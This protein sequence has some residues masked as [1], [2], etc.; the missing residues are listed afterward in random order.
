MLL[1]PVKR[2]PA[3]VAGGLLD[4][5]A[6][7]LLA[8]PEK[9]G[10][11]L[12]AGQ[13]ALSLAAGVDWLGFHIPEPRRVLYVQLEVAEWRLEERFQRQAAVIGVNQGGGM[14]D[15]LYAYT[16][17]EF[18]T[19]TANDRDHLHELIDTTK[20]DILLLD[21][22]YLIHSGDSNDESQ[23]SSVVRALNGLLK[24]VQGLVVVAHHAKDTQDLRMRRPAQ[25]ISGSSVLS[26]WPDSILTLESR[27]PTEKATL[28][29]T[30]R[31]AEAP[32][33]ITLKL[34]PATWLFERVLEIHEPS[35]NSDFWALDDRRAKQLL[36]TG[37]LMDDA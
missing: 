7:L 28:T 30:L 9:A 4:Q 37:G 16:D 21:P 23:M 17:F 34:D 22:L 11:S 15:R 26:R 33:R 6:K 25:R 18:S 35:E 19:A 2:P 1:R 5:G 8:G 14:Y 3:I 13:L 12:L 27:K 20:P 36:P 29:M 10:K 31:N 32:P 24:R